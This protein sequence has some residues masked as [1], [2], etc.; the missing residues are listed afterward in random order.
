MQV[1]VVGKAPQVLRILLPLRGKIAL[2]GVVRR[3][4]KKLVSRRGASPKSCVIV[5]QLAPLSLAPR[6]LS[7]RSPVRTL[8]T[9]APAPLT[10]PLSP[11]TPG[12]NPPFL[13]RQGRCLN[14]QKRRR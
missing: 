1:L 6:L 7:P 2:E 4:P 11:L 3:D 14:A 8:V 10:L 13:T 12:P 5:I 9:P